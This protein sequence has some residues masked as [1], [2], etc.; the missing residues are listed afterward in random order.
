MAQRF[1]INTSKEATLLASVGSA[2]V[3]FNLAGSGLQNV[4]ATPFYIRID[5]ETVSEEVCLVTGG[6]A[7]SL[8]VTRGYDGTATTS[9]SAGAVVRHIVA[10]EFFNKADAHV[11]ASSNVHGIGSGNNVVGDA[12]TQTLTNKTINA[13][14]TDVSHTTSPAASH[15][16]RV[17]ANAVTGRNGFVWDNTAADTGKAFLAKVAGVDKTYIEG[18]GDLVVGGSTTT[19]GLTNTGALTNNGLT[20]TT[21]LKSTGAVDFD[22]TL[23][24]DGTTN[25]GGDVTVEG[26]SRVEMLVPA[27]AHGPRHI[28]RANT[29]SLGLAVYDHLGSDN[30][31][32]YGNGQIATDHRLEIYD[33]NSP[34]IAVVNGTATVDSPQTEDI[35]YDLTDGQVKRYTGV[36]WSTVGYYGRTAGQGYAKWRA[37]AAQ[38][39]PSGAL[40]RVQFDTNV[41]SSADISASEAGNQLFTLNRSGVWAI[42]TV[43][44]LSTGTGFRAVQ[45]NNGAETEIYAEQTH[46]LSVGVTSTLSTGFTN[47]FNS[48]ET[49]R[50]RLFQDSGGALNTSPGG[51]TIHISFLWVRP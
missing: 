23:N 49:I 37:N 51:Q 39:I 36:T 20:T 1:Y 32:L 50:V 13:S 10:A 4:P 7:T 22:S 38:A 30:F 28:I 21:T 29:N 11:E 33:Q 17:H 47:Y 19:N 31:L 45:I 46:H 24:V 25:L 16:H 44:K 3:T 15:A 43:V 12:T 27:G 6:S 5:P 2:D 14:I 41:G 48:G 35:V 8:T 42:E 40:T 18:D 34:V 9:H 26:D